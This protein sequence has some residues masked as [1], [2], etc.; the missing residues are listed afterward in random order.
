M[1]IEDF[2]R[3][4]T[5]DTLFATEHLK[6]RMRERVIRYSDIERTI[7]RGQIIEEY[8]DDQPFPSCLIHD[9]DMHVVCSIGD[10]Y[11]YVIT[12]YRPSPDKWESDGR[13]RKE[14]MP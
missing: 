12:A 7:M 3:L 10:G 2:R 14:K 6:L 11:L 8:P 9:N 5:A 13:T 1:N 4:C